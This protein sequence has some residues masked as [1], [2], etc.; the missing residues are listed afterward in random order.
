MITNQGLLYIEPGGPRSAS[1]VMD[2]LTMVMAAA[3][4]QSE[5]GT[6]FGDGFKPGDSYPHAHICTCGAQSTNTTH[7]LPDGQITNSLATHYLT[8]HRSEVSAEQLA[9]VKALRAVVSPVYPTFDEMNGVYAP[10]PGC[11]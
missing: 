8:W 2:E 10:N 11:L 3:L 4:R 9:H 6:G 5:T 1:P 7:R